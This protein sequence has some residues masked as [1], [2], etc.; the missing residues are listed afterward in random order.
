MTKKLKEIIES[1]STKLGD[2]LFQKSN[3]IESLKESIEIKNTSN[4][5]IDDQ[6]IDIEYLNKI[7]SDDMLKIGE[8]GVNTGLLS[9]YKLKSK[10]HESL[11][12]I[13]VSPE[14]LKY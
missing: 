9:T 2:K 14:K 11:E 12:Y 6:N 5:L 4:L 3:K 7:I 1:I 8:S 10:R 13:K